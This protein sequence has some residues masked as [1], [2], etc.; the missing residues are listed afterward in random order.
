VINT[1]LSGDD[2]MGHKNKSP[3]EFIVLRQRPQLPK[4]SGFEITSPSAKLDDDVSALENDGVSE[5][6][7]DIDASKSKRSCTDTLLDALEYGRKQVVHNRLFDSESQPSERFP[8]AHNCSA[9]AYSVSSRMSHR[10]LRPPMPLCSLQFLED[11]P[12]VHLAKRS[13]KKWKG[14]AVNDRKANYRL[15]AT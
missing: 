14:K 4:V 10:I 5:T 15:E 6:G 12:A 9:S 8:S 3:F 11:L 7:E 1:K 2:K 13:G